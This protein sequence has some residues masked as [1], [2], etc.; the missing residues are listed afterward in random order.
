MY[1]S[2]ITPHCLE[3]PRGNLVLGSIPFQHLLLLLVY[4]GHITEKS[5]FMFRQPGGGT[6]Y[7][8]NPSGS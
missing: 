6:V 4:F 3:S 7:Y 5:V 1:L 2:G 8:M